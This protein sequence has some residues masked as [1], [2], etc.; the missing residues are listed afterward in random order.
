MMGS[1][2]NIVCVIPVYND[3]K[4]FRLLVA[5]IFDIFK[6]K[7]EYSV[8]VIAVDDASSLRAD[9]ASTKSPD[10]ETVDFNANLQ[11]LRLKIN[12]GHQRA[13][14]IGLQ[15][16][17]S[18]I[19]DAD[20]VV[21]LD[22]DG[23]DKP[24]DI[25]MLVEK[26]EELGRDSIVF[27][28]RKKRQESLSF[29]FGYRIF[30]ACFYILT[31][32]KLRFGNFSCIPRFLLKRVVTLENIWNHYSGAIVQS[33]IPYEKILIDRGKRYEGRS[34]M[35]SVG[36]ILHGLSAISVHF[37]L[38]SVRIL[39]LSA[40]GVLICV[41]AMLVVLYYKFFTDLAIPG[42]ASSLILIFFTIILQLSSVTLI[43]LL[44]QLSSRKNVKAPDEKIYKQFLTEN[45]S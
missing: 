6:K 36:L 39:K 15:Y 16:V 3:W 37:D 23:E 14:A 30:R 42:W 45:I 40:Y 22:A 31:G 32:K 38:L 13:I 25:P 10:A 7:A 17:N 12:V 2:I 18:E 43:V 1:P 20:F 24:V 26:C 29:K 19:T 4:S 44:M 34:K 9:F 27:A 35:T 11:I 8:R 21:V 5:E 33:R 28:Q 41:S